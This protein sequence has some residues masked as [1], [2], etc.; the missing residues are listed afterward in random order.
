MNT[1]EVLRGA[2]TLT[3]RGWCQNNYA[4][5]LKDRPV[6]NWHSDAVRWCIAGAVDR[7]VRYDIK[8]RN[9]ALDAIRE[10]IGGEESALD[11]NDAPERTQAEVLKA[12][13]DTI[14]RLEAK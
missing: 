4:L 6:E 2:R 8:L 12:L 5:D 11:W 1:V 14:A 3:E 13:D 10:T 9:A 7:V